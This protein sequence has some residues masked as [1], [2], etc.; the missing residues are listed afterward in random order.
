MKAVGHDFSDQKR[1]DI[2]TYFSLVIVYMK[3]VGHD[4]LTKKGQTF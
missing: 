3:A 2:L 4:F 1:S